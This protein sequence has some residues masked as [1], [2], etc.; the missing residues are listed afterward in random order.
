MLCYIL[1]FDKMRE[2]ITFKLILIKYDCDKTQFNCELDNN[3]SVVD[4][5]EVSDT[6]VKN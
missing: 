6:D 5:T 2:N 1:S 3:Y 4:G